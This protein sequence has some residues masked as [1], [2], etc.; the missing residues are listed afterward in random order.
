MDLPDIKIVIQWKATCDLCTL[1]QHFGRVAHGPGEV[2]TAIFLV[3]KKDTAEERVAKAG[4]AA[5]R[6]KNGVGIKRKAPGIRTD[7]ETRKQRKQTMKTSIPRIIM[8]RSRQ[9]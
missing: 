2:G 5:K 9:N 8:M 3:E 7:N 4:R 6:K 1:W